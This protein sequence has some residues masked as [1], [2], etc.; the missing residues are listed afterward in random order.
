MTN[1]KV[2]NQYTPANYHKWWNS[3]NNRITMMLMRLLIKYR[4]ENN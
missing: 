4:H 2:G 1:S 3:K